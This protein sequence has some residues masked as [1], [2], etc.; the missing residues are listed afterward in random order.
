MADRGLY[1]TPPRMISIEQSRNRLFGRPSAGA[2]HNGDGV[3]FRDPAGGER[4]VPSAEMK[5]MRRRSTS[6]MPEGL[7]AVLTREELRDLLAFL[8]SLK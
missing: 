2:R 1:S 6:V 5:E 3:L 8:Q 7:D 4:W